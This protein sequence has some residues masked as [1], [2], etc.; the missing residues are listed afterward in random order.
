MSTG[1]ERAKARE[2]A[3]AQRAH[4]QD[5][6]AKRHVDDTLTYLTGH[7]VAVDAVF[8]EYE[9]KHKNKGDGVCHD[10]AAAILQ[11]L[12]SADRARGWQWCMGFVYDGKIKHSWVEYCGWSVDMG[13]DGLLRMWPTFQPK[14]DI[15]NIGKIIFR[16]SADEARSWED[17]Q[18]LAKPP[19]DQDANEH[20]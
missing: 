18:A 11:D 13:D 10:L 15:K 6:A 12:K 1:R 8:N 2:A 19:N 20:K 16:K 7:G 3:A 4:E 9:A 5:E 14:P 17:A